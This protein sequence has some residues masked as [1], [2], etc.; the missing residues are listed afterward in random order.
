VA[1]LVKFYNIPFE[2]VVNTDKTKIRLMPMGG[3]NTWEEKGTKR[4]ALVGQKDKRQVVVAVSSSL[5]GDILPF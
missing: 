5:A 2:L 3:T 4:V 1:Y